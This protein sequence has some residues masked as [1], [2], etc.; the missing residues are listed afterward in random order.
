MK[1]K[2]PIE[3]SSKQLDRVLAFFPRI[4]TKASFLFAVNTSI[5]GVTALNLQ[6]GDIEIW[7]MITLAAGTVTL[8]LA[9]LVFLYRCSYPHLDGGERSLVYFREIAKMR[10]ADFIDSFMQIDEEALTR[11][12]LGQVWRN[13]EILAAKFD[14][15][16]TAFI[17]TAIALV[18]WTTYLVAAGTIH[19]QLPSL[20]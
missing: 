12:Y 13:S 20:H 14:A 2:N 4:E 8:S 9:S 16:K 15:L 6:P 5:L 18:P 3:I 19:A 7:Y 11:D 10:E 1:N 17:L